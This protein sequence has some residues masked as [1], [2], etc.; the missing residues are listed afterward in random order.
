MVRP[1]YRLWGAGFATV[2]GV[3]SAVVALTPVKVTFTMSAIALTIA[4][5]SSWYWAYRRTKPRHLPAP[6]E[7]PLKAVGRL[8]WPGTGALARQANAMA[9]SFYG[10]EAIPFDRYEL[11][12]LTNPNILVCLTDETNEV[13]GY[14]DVLPLKHEAMEMFIQ[15]R[16]LESEFQHQDLYAADAMDQCHRLYLAGIAVRHPEHHADKRNAAILVWALVKYLEHFY[17]RD[18]HERELFALASTKEGE[19]LIR[20]FPFEV[21]RPAEAREDHHNLYRLR[22]SNGTLRQVLTVMPD[23]GNVVALPWQAQSAHEIP[24]P[25]A[26]KRAVR[27]SR[28]RK[29]VASTDRA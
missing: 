22:I 29:R 2:T 19:D 14:F 6:D 20:G 25:R 23:W 12:R 4:A 28:T 11:W 16:L 5:A 10:R 7:L 9:A 8:Q 17:G 3:T 18:G 15:G 1:L 27:G 13:V 24:T 21:A 26:G